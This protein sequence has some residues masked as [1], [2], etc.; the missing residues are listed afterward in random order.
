MMTHDDLNVPGLCADQRK[1]LRALI[2]D[3][4]FAP[5]EAAAAYIKA[6]NPWTDIPRA[7]VALM[8]AGRL[9]KSDLIWRIARIAFREAAR[10][11]RLSHLAQYAETLSAE[12]WTEARAA[13][14]AAADDAAAYAAAAAYADDAAARNRVRD[15]IVAMVLDEVEHAESRKGAGQ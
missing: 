3:G 5:R 11:E 7:Y 4:P 12:N 9:P 15:E 14:A 2:G 1:A 6:G 8:R 13:A 10:I